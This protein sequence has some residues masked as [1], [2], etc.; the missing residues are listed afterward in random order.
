MP[1]LRRLGAET[2]EAASLMLWAHALGRDARDN[3]AGWLLCHPRAR[4]ALLWPQSLSQAHEAEV[5]TASL[6][7]AAA[8]PP[9]AEAVTRLWFWERMVAR[10]H[11]RV[12]LREVP[13]RAVIL[14]VWLGYVGR[15]AKAG[16]RH[17]LVV[18]SGLSGE[19]LPVLKSAVL[20][21]L[22]QLAGARESDASA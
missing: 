12:A 8:S 21:E 20:W 15:G 18:L 14:P 7:L 4:R 3:P 5:S 11:W 9:S 13:P 1:R 19:P 17:R 22:G 10:R 16:G 6:R 2:F